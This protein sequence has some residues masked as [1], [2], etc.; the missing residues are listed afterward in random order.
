[1]LLL[2]R[3]LRIALLLFSVVAWSQHQTSIE[4]NVTIEKKIVDVKQTFTYQNDSQQPL[5]ELIFYN[6]NNAYSQKKSALTQRFSDEFVRSFFLAGRAEKGYTRIN[7]ITGAV[8]S[9]SEMGNGKDLL[10]IVLKEPLLPGKSVELT[11]DYQLRIPSAKFNGF[12]Y[13]KNGS[14]LLRDVFLMPAAFKDGRFLAYE[15]DNGSDAAV[16]PTNVHFTVN[17]PYQLELTTDLIPTSENVFIQNNSKNFDFFITAKNRFTTVQHND[18]M[19]VTDIKLSGKNEFEKIISMN[20]IIDFTE[21]FLNKNLQ[22]KILVTK[23]DYDQRPFYGLNQLP[24]FLRP[25]SDDFVFEI[26]FAKVF[27]QKY[28]EKNTEIDKR[29]NGFL[30]DGIAHYMLMAYIDTYHSEQKMLGRLSKY[31]LFSNFNLS[32]VSFNDQFHYH[33]LLMARKNLDQPLNLP[34]DQQIKFNHNIANRAKFA[35]VLRYIDEYL[36]NNSVSESIREFLAQKE[37]SFESFNNILSKK[38]DHKTDK[39][40]ENL[41]AN[42]DATDF[43]FSEIHIEKDSISFKIKSNSTTSYPIPIYL[44]KKKE[45]VEK[46]WIWTNTDT[47]YKLP[48]NGAN[49]LALNYKNEFPEYNLRN[50]STAIDKS[51]FNKPFTFAIMKDLEAPFFNQVLYV[52]SLSYNLYDGISPGLRFHN[53][54]MLDKPFNFD[55]NPMYSPNT[56]RLIGHFSF[57]GNHNFRNS[58]WFNLRYQFAGSFLHYAPEASYLKLNPAVFLRWR[59]PNFRNNEK[60]LLLV[61][62]VFVQKQPYFLNP[63]DDVNNYSVFNARYAYSKSEV[64]KHFSFTPDFQLSQDFSKVSLEVDYRKLLTKNHQLSLRFFGG[65]FLSNRTTSD[66]FSFGIDRPT[67]YLFDY[68][69]YGRSESTGIFSQQIIL[70]DAAFKSILPQRFSNQW[71]TSLN[72]GIGIWNWIEL[73]GDAAVTKSRNTSATFIYDSGIRLNLVTD[74][75]EVYLPVNSSNGWE[76]AQPNYQEKIRFIVTLDPKILISLFTRKWF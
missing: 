43:T 63:P 52:P 21:N 64:L 55:V 18:L 24:K 62:N 9:Y 73:Y 75:F 20:R 51:L 60:Q 65:T 57:A 38:S 30:T 1:M 14:L 5:T 39:I 8:A 33:Y 74:F 36:N 54:T 46:K 47:L 66:Y 41:V 76:I 4:A 2:Q 29:S 22:G 31:K 59:N 10:K 34:A 6:W 40:I 42:R 17:N 50:N 61:R 45:I 15:N 68:M 19:V 11:F 44:L 71:I 28:L 69:Y 67:D 70:T 3:A 25:F 32:K 53:K 35:I 23:A 56:Q 13:E 48:K 12:G 37:Q 7:A 58:N 27:I 26:Q 49:R 72:A 16:A